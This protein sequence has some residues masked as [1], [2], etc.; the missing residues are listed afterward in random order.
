MKRRYTSLFVFDGMDKAGKTTVL[1]T[2]KGLTKNQEEL[3]KAIESIAPKEGFNK[4]YLKGILGYLHE[5]NV[6]F[7]REPTSGPYGIEIRKRLSKIPSPLELENLSRED[8]QRIKFD[9]YDL[10]LLFTRDRA[11][12]FRANNIVEK[13][14]SNKCIIFDRF[15]Y[16]TL[17]YQS[18]YM[19]RLNEAIDRFDEDHSNAPGKIVPAIMDLSRDFPNPPN[20]NIFLL[21]ISKGLYDERCKS[22]GELESMEKDFNFQLGVASK[23]RNLLDP[24]EIA[25]ITEPMKAVNHFLKR[26]LFLITSRTLQ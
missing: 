22:G 8:L 11:E 5:D 21:T 7:Y 23:F 1:E 19:D 16:S 4:S 12:Q 13:L 25:D 17:A 24:H 18:T 20:K 3:A 9:I 15:Y 14:H 26:V 10:I 6:E 2:I